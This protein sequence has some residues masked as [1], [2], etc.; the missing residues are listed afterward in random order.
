[1]TKTAR[2]GTVV[3]IDVAVYLSDGTGDTAATIDT[4]TTRLDSHPAAVPTVTQIGASAHNKKIRFTGLNPEVADGD[5]IYAF[6]NGTG[7]DGAWSEWIERIEVN[8]DQRGTDDAA[9]ATE[10]AKVPKV[11]NPQTWA[12]GAGD[13]H[14]VTITQP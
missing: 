1:M 5:I 12:N 11:D 10:L 2:P 6:I 9:L 8:A 3:E 4:A 14:Q 7:T 13:T